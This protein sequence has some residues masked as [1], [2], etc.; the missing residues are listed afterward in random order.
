MTEA[1]RA[2]ERMQYLEENYG[3]LMDL[4]EEHNVEV[5]TK[6]NLEGIEK[7][8]TGAEV[9]EESTS[10]SDAEPELG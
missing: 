6:V 3:W 9:P 10:K 2:A 8:G 5:D 1:E 7:D 4:A